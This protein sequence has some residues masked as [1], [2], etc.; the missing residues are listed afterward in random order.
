MA[1]DI[2]DKLRSIEDMIALVGA[3][4]IAL[5]GASELK[6]WPYNRVAT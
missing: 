2:A 1:A 6:I 5:V 4:E 3:S